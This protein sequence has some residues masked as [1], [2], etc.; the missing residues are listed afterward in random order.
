MH[1]TFAAW[2]LIL[3]SF[4][5]VH[6]VCLFSSHLTMKP[7]AWNVTRI[8]GLLSCLEQMLQGSFFLQRNA[9]TNCTSTPPPMQM[10]FAEVLQMNILYSTANIS[11]SPTHV[12]ACTNARQ[13]FSH[14]C[15]HVHT[16]NKRHFFHTHACTC[17]YAHTH[18]C[19]LPHVFITGC[20]HGLHLTLIGDMCWHSYIQGVPGGMCET[21]G[22][23]FL[24]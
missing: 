12:C 3:Y 10:Y 9:S 18:T 13:S 23:C 11:F 15:M 21:S 1:R 22:E 19:V 24:C 17:A 16:P 4:S 20:H 14:T 6:A 2:A 7:V 8:C 5:S